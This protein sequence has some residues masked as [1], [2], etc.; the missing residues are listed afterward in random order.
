MCR[1]CSYV[2]TL[3]RLREEISR[4]SEDPKPTNSRKKHL[5]ELKRHANRVEIALKERREEEDIKD[6]KLTR[7]FSRASTK[8]AMVA[9]VRMHSLPFVTRIDTRFLLATVRTCPP[10]Q[11]LDV[12]RRLRTEELCPR[13]LR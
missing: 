3:D 8:Q 10:P 4:L 13:L 1:H 6:L 2:A 11:S 9:R 7:V 12:I 5:R